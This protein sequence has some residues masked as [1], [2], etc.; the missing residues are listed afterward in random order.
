MWVILIKDKKGTSIVNAFQKIISKGRKTNKLW[1]DQGREFY[2]NSFKDFLKINNIEMYSIYNEGKSVVAERFIRT[3]KNKIFKHMT[4]IS[5][6][7]YFDLLD[8]IVDKC[9][10]TIHKT[11]KM[12]HID[13]TSDSYGE[14]NENPNKKEP[15]FKVGD[16]VRISKCKNI[17]P[18]GYTPNWSEEVFVI[19]QIKNTAPWTYVINDLN[20]EE[21]TG[22]FY[23]K[24]L[25]KTN[26]IEFRIEKVFKRKG[27]KLY[28]KWKGYDNRFNSWID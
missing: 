18:K 5:K 23:E 8:D 1:V 16:H 28:V 26:H 11:I 19:S 12:K 14:Y 21:I 13:V 7:V 27:D 10:N 3:I 24:E 20:G 6:N 2:K 17:F 9:N 25:Q 22:S 15:K 4:A